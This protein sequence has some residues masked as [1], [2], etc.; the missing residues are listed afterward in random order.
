M[1]RYISAIF[2]IKLDQH[3]EL[4]ELNERPIKLKEF[5]VRVEARNYFY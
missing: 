3:V 4:V 2:E 5:R 1:R